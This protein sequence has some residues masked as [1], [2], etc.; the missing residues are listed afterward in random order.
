VKNTYGT[1]CFLLKNI[2]DKP[3]LSKHKLLTTVA[4]HMGGQTLYALEGSVFNAGAAIEW[5]IREMRLVVDVTEI[6]AICNATPDTGGVVFVP[7]FSGLGAPYWDANARGLICGMD[8]GTNKNHIVRALM[9]SIAYQSR[10]VIDCMD[11]EAG[12][13]VSRLRVD[14]GVS[15][16][17]FTMQFQ[18]DISGIPAERPSDT[19]TTALG[20]AYLAGLAV[21]FWKDT[22]EIKQLRC[23]DR[24]FEPLMGAREAEVKYA[25]WKA[26]VKRFGVK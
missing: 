18:A 22:D 4:W 21:G 9:E 25:E 5:L 11:A 10:D 7:A 12:A 8:L 15:K 23:V 17:D 26:A 24:L 1:G 13:R 20:A 19:E 16:S 3:V 14:G 6:N 2:G